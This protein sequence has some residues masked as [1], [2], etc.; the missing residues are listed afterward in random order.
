MLIMF[1]KKTIL[2][3]AMLLAV[4]VSSA[5]PVS[6]YKNEACGH[7]TMYLGELN[8]YLLS[9][10]G[11]KIID[12]NMINDPS[13]R[14]ELN[15]LNQKYG[16]PVQFQ[17]HMVVNLNDEIFLEGHV[18]IAI[19]KEYFADPGK[20]KDVLAIYQDSMAPDATDFKILTR[21]G[22]ENDCKISGGLEACTQGT[23]PVE[24]ESLFWLVV[25]SGL[26]AGIH[27]CTISVLLFFIAFLITMRK[28]RLNIF[29]IGSAY[30]FG[31]FLA[32][33]FIGLGVLKAF[34]FGQPHLAA[35]VAGAMVLILGLA[36]LFNFLFPN[37]EKK[38]SF[39]IP[40]S[41]KEKIV[42]LVHE[43]SV[44]AA[45][46]IGIIVG[47]CSF[48]CT[49]GIYFSIT[50]LL[51]SSSLTGASML[52]LYNIMFILPLIAI[53]IIA[54]DKRMVERLEQAEKRDVRLVKLVSALLMIALA[55]Y[56]LFGLDH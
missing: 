16:I 28:T 19:V 44:P 37:R 3:I 5:Y 49:A 13:A 1:Q 33:F 54:T 50:G 35:K 36:N 45:L 6:I 12:R 10:D 2:L 22:K 11:V 46:L 17:G 39:G 27:P 51:I 31:I 29:G 42:E 8:D 15:A 40:D 55:A 7:C 47:I 38:L 48:G 14:E 20:Y 53:L 4:P 30:I 26:L 34:S 32:Y 24:S 56:L 9:I 18:P 52:L 21:S 23:S 41:A 25:A 43:G